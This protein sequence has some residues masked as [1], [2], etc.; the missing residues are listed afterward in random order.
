MRRAEASISPRVCSAAATVLLCGRVGYDD[1][2]FGGGLYIYVVHPDA[3]PAY[4]LQVIARSMTSAVTLGRA[5]DYEAV[6]LS[7]RS[8]N[9]PG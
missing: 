6:V 1:A 2:A 7:D 8:S 4:G 9:S 3:R 5:A